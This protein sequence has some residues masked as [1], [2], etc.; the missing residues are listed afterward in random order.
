MMCSRKTETTEWSLMRKANTIEIITDRK[1]NFHEL[2]DG[3][4]FMKDYKLLGLTEGFSYLSRRTLNGRKH[5]STMS[6]VP[7]VILVSVRCLSAE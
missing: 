7:T 5:I 2:N 4:V 1:V 3:N 6:I